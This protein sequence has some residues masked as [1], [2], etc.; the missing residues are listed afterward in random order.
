MHTKVTPTGLT[1]YQPFPYPKSLEGLDREI[2]KNTLDW[3]EFLAEMS[4]DYSMT[5]SELARINRYRREH[6]L[7]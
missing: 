4:D 5:R 6:A 1:I 2:V 7:G 3:Y